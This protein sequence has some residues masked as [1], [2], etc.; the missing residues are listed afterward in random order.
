MAMDFPASPTVGQKYPTTPVPGMPVYTWDGEKW[1]ANVDTVYAPPIAASAVPKPD[2]AVGSVGT[3]SKYARED[4]AHP[5]TGGLMREDEIAATAAE[6]TRHV[7]A[8]IE[9]IKA[10]LASLRVRLADLDAAI[11]GASDGV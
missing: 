10:D 8:D 4:H 9:A 6:I 3:S 2:A 5:N 7:S 11:K 1:A